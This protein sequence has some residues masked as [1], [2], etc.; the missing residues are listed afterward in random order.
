MGVMLGELAK[1]SPT[2]LDELSGMAL[3]LIEATRRLPGWRIPRQRSA[4]L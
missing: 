2:P 4:E 3:D 1:L